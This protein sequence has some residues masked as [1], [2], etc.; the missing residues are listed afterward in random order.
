VNGTIWP[1]L[2]SSGLSFWLLTHRS[3]VPFPTL[4]KFLRSCG[5]G[6]GSSQPRENKWGATWKKKQWLRTR[7]LRLTVVGDP[8]RWPRDTPLSADGGTK[9]HPPVADAVLLIF[10]RCNFLQHQ[11]FAELCNIC[12]LHGGNYDECRL[13]GYKYPVRTSQETHYVSVTET[14]WLMLC[15]IWGFHGS[16]LWTCR[17]LG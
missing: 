2:S 14:S 4:Q 10:L 5:S 16:W 3:W 9:I 8:R 7:K 11:R 15:K 17:L 1:L 13:L 6:P 12:G